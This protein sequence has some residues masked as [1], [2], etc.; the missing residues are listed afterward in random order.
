MKR[1]LIFGARGF[2]GG[3]VAAAAAP[4]FEVVSADRDHRVEIANQQAC[5]QLFDQVRP[6]YVLML[7]ALSDI[8]RCE[9]E[10]DLAEV[11][12]VHGPVNVARECL[13]AGARLLFTSSG[14]VYDGNAVSYSEEDPTSPISVYGK[15]KA[16]AEAAL[17][18]MMPDVVIA[19][20]S[21][22]L[23]LA[24]TAGTNAVVNRLLAS[25]NAGQVVQAPV[26]EYRNAIHAS[27]A[28]SFL[29]QLATQNESR[30]IFHIGSAN[31]LSRFDITR[32][33]AAEFGFAD[34]LVQPQERPPAN[35]APRGRHEFLRTEKIAAVCG[36]RVPTCEQAIERCASATAQTHS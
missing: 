1:L 33:L 29:L 35:R 2:L 27:T 26:N 6:D 25:W 3:W 34:H 17:A 10:P 21:L 4:A 5:R 15:T 36:T 11:V 22:V 8:D 12:N 16:R 30:G 13:R 14:A 9:R 20:L 19:R 32:A 18:A 31:V 28:A 7:A 23:G 24:P